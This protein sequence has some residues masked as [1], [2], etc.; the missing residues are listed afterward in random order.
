[1][2]LVAKRRKTTHIQNL[3]IRV[4]DIPTANGQHVSQYRGHVPTR[5]C[6]CSLQQ[7]TR[8][9]CRL[10][11]RGSRTRQALSHRKT[12]TALYSA[13]H[14]DAHIRAVLPTCE[15]LNIQ[16]HRL[17]NKHCVC[18]YLQTAI[19]Q[20][21]KYIVIGRGASSLQPL[22]QNIITII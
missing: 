21:K 13:G 18:F 16:S 17:T 22:R 1:M 11:H 7:A 9:V 19:K 3:I 10:K 5:R 20:K 12:A 2:L 8:N 4:L 14:D 15:Q 6:I